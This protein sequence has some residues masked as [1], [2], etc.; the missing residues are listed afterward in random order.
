MMGD[1]QGS[2]GMALV[3]LRSH[4]LSGDKASREAFEAVWATNMRRFGDMIGKKPVLTPEQSKSLKQFRRARN[5]FNVI[6]TKMINIRNGEEWNQANYWLR[7]KVLPAV[8]EIE[9]LLSEMITTQQQLMTADSATAAQATH[10]LSNLLW[11]LLGIGIVLSALI[12]FLVTRAM[13][14]PLRRVTAVA[15]HMSQGDF[16]R[17]IDLVQKDEVGA[18]AAAFRAL[19]D[20]VKGI[21]QAATAIST[22]DL[23]VQVE[24]KSEH[25]LLSQSFQRM[26]SN[27]RQVVQELSEHATVL[28]QAVNDLSAASA[29]VSSNSG[30]LSSKI[31]TT[32][33]GGKEVSEN[34]SVVATSTE[35]MTATIGEIAQNTEKARQTTA[36]AMHSVTAATSQVEELNT[37]AAAISQVTN[38][39]MEIADQ[40][41]L[42]AL[43]AT[44]EAARAGEAGKGFAVVANEVKEL[45]Q[46]T[47]SATEDIRQRIE[48]IQQST[49]KAVH[50]IAQI[51]TVVTEVNESVSSIASAVEE[52][53]V[54]TKD[55]AQTVSRVAQV[56]HDIAQDMDSVSGVSTQ[57]QAT[58]TQL[59]QQAEALAQMGQA[60]QEMVGK[61]TL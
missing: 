47:N 23:T 11:L 5:A 26:A 16:S 60:L 44:I 36:Q 17:T 37:T 53:A 14:T 31:T 55:M 10:M 18:L 45:A 56:S 50:E 34:I 39:I 3:T 54:T 2:L 46:Q 59:Q 35:E 42:L 61:F 24:A 28:N 9:T 21:A 27:L 19:T 40:T 25:D 12:A 1:I 57:M 58:S 29:Q 52:Q 20:Y 43:N 32:A 13:T 6:Q 8:T 30:E 7:T 4:I 51:N 22:G 15:Q 49:T 33:T 48:A 38:T 41:K